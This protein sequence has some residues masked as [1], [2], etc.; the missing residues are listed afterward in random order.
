MQAGEGGEVL[1]VELIG[2][3]GFRVGD[4]GQPLDLRRNVG[5]L[6]ELPDGEPG[7]FYGNDRI[8][9]NWPPL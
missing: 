4:V 8:G 7:R 3:T 1:Q 2:A 9:Q 5:E 6:L